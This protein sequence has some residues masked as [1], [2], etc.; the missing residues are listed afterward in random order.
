MVTAGIIPR[1]LGPKYYGDFNFLTSTFNQL[2]GFLDMG[3]SVGFYNKVSQRQNEQGLM[4]FYFNFLAVGSCLMLVFILFLHATGWYTTIFPDQKPI[5]IYMSAILS[6]L[7]WFG[8]GLDQ[9]TDAFGLTI[10][11]ERARILQKALGAGLLVMLFIYQMLTLRNYFYYQYFNQ[12][13]LSGMFLW[14]I[15]KKKTSYSSSGN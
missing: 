12:L 7:I 1:G 14:V 3:V 5:F 9:M 6:I 8:Q 15:N 11:G 10:Y 2:K 4:A 13:L